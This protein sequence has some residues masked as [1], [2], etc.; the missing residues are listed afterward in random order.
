MDRETAIY[1][2]YDDHRHRDPAEA[3]RNLMRAVLRTAMEDIR[4]RGEPYR[5][6]RRYFLSTD[7]L[8]AFSFLNV[9][10]HLD[11]C[12]RT[13]RTVVGLTERSPMREGAG[14]PKSDESMAA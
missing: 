3:E 2:A 7:E 5:D 11:L 1:A 12:P 14:K 8:Y 9:C 13:I 4:K 10:Y 6:A